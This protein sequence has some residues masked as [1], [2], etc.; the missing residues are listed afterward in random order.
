MLKD[1]KDESLAEARRMQD[2]G[3]LDCYV[4]VTLFHPDLYGQYR[5]FAANNR[6]KIVRYYRTFL[7]SL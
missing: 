6:D 5:D 1:S 2:A 4:L 7:K 3:F